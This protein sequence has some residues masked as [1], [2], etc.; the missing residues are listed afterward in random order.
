MVL[1]DMNEG[2]KAPPLAT[3][4]IPTY[5]R[6]RSLERCVQSALAQDFEHFEVLICDNASTD[7]TQEF[8]EAL[9]RKD[10]RVRY[11]RHPENKGPLFNFK[12]TLEAARGGYFFWLGSDDRI[13]SNY[14]RH[15]FTHLQAH[16][17]HVLVSGRIHYYKEDKFLFEEP[18]VNIHQAGIHGRVA[19]FY[20]GIGCNGVTYGVGRRSDFLKIP[21][22]QSMGWDWLFIAGL[23]SLGKIRSIDGTIIHRDFTWDDSSFEQ[24][25]KTFQL[26]P[27]QQ[28]NPY[29]AIALLAWDQIQNAD[30]LFGSLTKMQRWLLAVHAVAILRRRHKIG[31]LRL[32]R[33]FMNGEVR[34]LLEDTQKKSAS[35]QR[36]YGPRET[37]SL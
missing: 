14:L 2:R 9:A 26:T 29:L 37:D 16:P 6:R 19:E 13:D 12:A 10:H 8:V 20:R 3:I 32:L 28:K 31:R 33:S 18:Q 7:D 5:N 25:T 21:F 30:A 34:R 24:I 15:C 36:E 35:L 17:D 1:H 27:F 11:I 22:T 4:G 23:A